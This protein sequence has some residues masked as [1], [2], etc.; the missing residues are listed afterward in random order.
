MDYVEQ[1][2]ILDAIHDRED[3]IRKKYWEDVDKL[4]YQY[5]PVWME[6]LRYVVP[7]TEKVKN[8]PVAFSRNHII[9]NE[10]W[11]HTYTNVEETLLGNEMESNPIINMP[12]SMLRKTGEY[13][14]RTVL[15]H[16]VEHD[17]VPFIPG[18]LE[19]NEAI[20]K[21]WLNLDNLV[22]STKDYFLN[23]NGVE[24]S[25][26]GS[27]IKNWFGLREGQRLTGDMIRK[28]QKHYVKT[29]TERKMIDNNM[30]ELL[31][32]ITDPDKAAEWFNKYAL[33]IGGVG[34]VSLGT[35]LSDNK[36]NN[37]K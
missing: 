24:L 2:K 27:Q 21:E 12:T 26:R 15:G 25:A 34:A 19:E 8:Y 6:D 35:S 11:P 4:N 23:G 3:A 33:G 16:E 37:I 36:K 30:T 13:L 17:I 32:N 1:M 20:I 5:S 7:N 28:A 31:D 9:G 29:T 22:E 10:L 14:K 18:T